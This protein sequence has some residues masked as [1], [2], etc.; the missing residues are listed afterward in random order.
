MK[1]VRI[2]NPL[3]VLGNKVSVPDTEGLMI[4]K[5]SQHPQIAL[6]IE[7][8]KDICDM[9]DW[10]KTNCANYQHLPTYCVQCSRSHCLTNDR[11]SSIVSRSEG[12]E[13]GMGEGVW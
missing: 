5:L 10:W 1:T 3:Y 4:L 13:G 12:E 8:M 11:S 6:Q 2:F 7:V 9:S